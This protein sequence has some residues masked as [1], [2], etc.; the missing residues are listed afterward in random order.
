MK[1]TVM[2]LVSFGVASFGFLLSRPGQRVTGP[3]F[4]SMIRQHCGHP[5]ALEVASAF[6]RCGERFTIARIGYGWQY[7]PAVR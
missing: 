1:T 3:E 5:K 6:E 2:N 4:A 7:G